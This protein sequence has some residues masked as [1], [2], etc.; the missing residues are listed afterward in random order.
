MSIKRRTIAEVLQQDILE[1]EKQEEK[2]LSGHE[3]NEFAFEPLNIPEP[4]EKQLEEI[5][6]YRMSEKKYANLVSTLALFNG[7]HNFHN[8]IP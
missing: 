3:T 5:K 6:S 1:R 2:Q 8:Y 4:T 7:T